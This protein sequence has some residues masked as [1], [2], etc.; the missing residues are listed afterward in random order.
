VESWGWAHRNVK[1]LIQVWFLFFAGFGCIFLVYLVGF[2]DVRTAARFLFVQY[3][4]VVLTQNLV[5]QQWRV[6]DIL[7]I[8]WILPFL[9][10]AAIGLILMLR[11]GPASRLRFFVLFTVLYGS[12]QLFQLVSRKIFYHQNL[13]YPAL[14]PVLG[15]GYL[16]GRLDR[17]SLRGQFCGVGILGLLAVCSIQAVRTHNQPFLVEQADQTENEIAS[18]R[19]FTDLNCNVPLDA[20]LALSRQGPDPGIAP[21]YCLS[22]QDQLRLTDFL[23]ALD[24][25]EN[26]YAYDGFGAYISARSM[27]RFGGFMFSAYH[28]GKFQILY[29]YLRNGSDLAHRVLAPVFPPLFHDMEDPD[30][31]ESL[32]KELSRYPPHLYLLDW[33]VTGLLSRYPSLRE[34]VA[35]DFDILLVPR[36]HSI[37]A[38]RKGVFTLG[39]RITWC[40]FGSV[41]PWGAG[42]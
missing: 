38:V 6:E 15:I 9:L 22:L 41:D 32:V 3:R 13:I 26:R 7:Q 35:R 4:L 29:R 30:G 40:D 8:T 24:G 34:S 21:Q 2:W 17:S 39:D 16:L 28:G 20:V 18:L 10:F 37:V 42:R 12:E 27:P 25:R 36:A 31:E 14:F 1:G 23:S 33:Y 5:E 11:H 19:P